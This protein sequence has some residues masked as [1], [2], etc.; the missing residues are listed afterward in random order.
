MKL[1]LL[2]ILLIPLLGFS[3]DKKIEREE[4]IE[5]NEMPEA[6]QQYL[7]QNMPEKFRRLKFYF[8]TD[9]DKES[10]EA[11]FKHKGHRYSVEFNKSGKLQDIEVKIDKKEM[12]EGS[13]KKIE[14]FLKS[15]HERFKIEKIQAQYLARLRSPEENMQKSLQRKQ[16]I[17]DNYELIVAT[18]NDGKLKKYEFLFDNKGNFKEER[19]IIRNSYDYLI[20]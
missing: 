6:A 4:D 5:S 15:N 20:F 13:L 3:Q 18:K 1:K 19:E 9:G 7:S 12:K 8:E 16:S 10:F 11:K 2:F 14:S 17:P